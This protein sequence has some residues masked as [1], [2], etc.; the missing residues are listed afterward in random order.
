MWSGGDLDITFAADAR[1]AVV[2]YDRDRVPIGHGQALPKGVGTGAEQ[3]QASTSQLY[4]P[5]LAPGF[6]V[7][8]LTGPATH[9]SVE[10]VAPPSGNQAVYLPLAVR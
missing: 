8:E 2:L 10:F 3:G 7:F 1:L 4:I 9:Y 5:Q 6:Y